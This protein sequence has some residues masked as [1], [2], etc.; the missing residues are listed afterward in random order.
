MNVA[1]ESRSD[2]A[3]GEGRLLDAT[4]VSRRYYLQDHRNPSVKSEAQQFWK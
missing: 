4:M 2:L 3:R 1:V